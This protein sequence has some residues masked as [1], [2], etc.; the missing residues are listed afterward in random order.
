M[1]S[2]RARLPRSESPLLASALPAVVVHCT[3]HG[4]ERCC[5]SRLP[6][7]RRSR[8]WSRKN[9]AARCDS[10]PPLASN[11][12]FTSCCFD[13]GFYCVVISKLRPEIKDKLNWGLSD[14]QR[15]SR[16]LVRMCV[17]PFC[18]CLLSLFEL[19]LR[20]SA[21]VRR[22][23][24]SSRRERSRRREEGDPRAQV[25]SASNG[26]AFRRSHS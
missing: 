11:L 14:W 25:R 19:A 21:Q 3:W 17:P 13:Q 1:D 24:L 15:I 5:P 22:L 9:P 12:P 4:R 2:A 20:V 6:I 10:V 16:E 7:A 8:A 23:S 26:V 18:A